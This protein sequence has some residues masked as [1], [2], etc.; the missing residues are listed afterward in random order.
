MTTSRRER[1]TAPAP[2]PPALSLRLDGYQ[3][4]RDTV[5]ESGA[6][7]Y[8][9]HGRPGAPELFLKHG[10]ND[11]A[12]MLAEEMARLLRRL[13][14][15]APP[16]PALCQKHCAP[17]QSVAADHVPPT[18]P[19]L[20]LPPLLF[21]PLFDQPI[22]HLA[23]VADVPIARSDPPPRLRYCSLLI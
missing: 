16:P 9:L 22:S 20:A 6:A 5:G 10:R 18:V 4:A 15:K 21:A 3:W 1:R 11:V 7:V 8:R 17:D 19:A 23:L 12:G 2:L 13:P 14:A